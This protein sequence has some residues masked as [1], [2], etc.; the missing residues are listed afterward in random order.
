MTGRYRKR[1]DRQII[2]C[3]IVLCVITAAVLMITATCGEDAPDERSPSPAL[4]SID[5][6]AFIEPW[7]K[8]NVDLAAWAVMA[9]ENEWGYVYGTWGNVLTQEVLEQKL[10]Q[11]PNSVGEYEDFIRENLMNRRATDC[12]GL[13]KGYCWYTPAIGFEYCANGMP[14]MGANGLF[15]AAETSGTID[16]IPETVGLAVWAQDHIGIYIGG[17]WVIDARGT[18]E[19]V[20]KTRLADRAFTHWCKIPYIKYIG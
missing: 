19:G 17:G 2:I 18:L 16:T 14:D 1:K 11:Y 3:L 20:E 10:I 7:S 12:V 13:I 6:S 15:N 8:N 9:Y 4:S 5:T